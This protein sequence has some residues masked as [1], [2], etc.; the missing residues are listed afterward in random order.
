MLFGSTKMPKSSYTGPKTIQ[1]N[2]TFDF[3][4]MKEIEALEI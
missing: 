2:F 4:S 1:Y 3:R